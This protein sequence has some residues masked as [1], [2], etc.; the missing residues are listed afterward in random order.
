MNLKIGDHV[1]VL[2]ETLEGVITNI[3]GDTIYIRD[4]DD[5]L[6]E[7]FTSQVVKIPQPFDID[8]K[9]IEQVVFKERQSKNNDKTSSSSNTKQI[10]EIDLH[11][12]ELTDSTRKMTDHEMLQLQLQAAEK[13]LLKAIEKKEKKLIFIHGIGKGRLKSELY[14]LFQRYRQVDFY[15]ADFQKYGFG[16]TEVYIFENFN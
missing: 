12:H 7:Y 10:P 14:V 15:D 6:Y 1:Q 11:I 2:D 3:N 13:R 9:E 5:F 16:A 8:Q 4:K